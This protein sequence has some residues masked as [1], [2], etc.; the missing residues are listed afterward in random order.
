MKCFTPEYVKNR[1]YNG[2]NQKYTPVPC[3]YCAACLKKRRS[4]WSYR[5]LYELKQHSYSSFITLTYE[6]DQLPESGLEK[7][8]IQKYL[9]KIR[10]KRKCRYYCVGEYGSQTHRPHYHAI[11]FGIHSA[12]PVLTNSWKYGFVHTG[13]VTEASIGYVTK[14]LITNQLPLLE[15]KNDPLVLCLANRCLDIDILI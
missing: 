7:D 4:I 6:D 12:D 9:K 14:Y 1:T 11:I 15:K 2:F 8:H 3:G 10:K 13:T 5:L